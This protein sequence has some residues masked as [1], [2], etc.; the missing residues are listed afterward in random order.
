MIL[1]AI[2]AV[3]IGT[4]LLALLAGYGLGRAEA[5]DA[6]RWEIN[7]WKR[8]VAQLELDLHVRHVSAEPG[9]R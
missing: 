1:A 3:M 8:R 5:N 4:S 6:A 9:R 2:A 7:L